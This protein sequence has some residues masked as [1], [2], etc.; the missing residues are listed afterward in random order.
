MRVLFRV[1]SGPTIG[2]GHAARS[3][4]LAGAVM[5]AGAEVTILGDHPDPRFITP[6]VRSGAIAAVGS[7]ADVDMGSYDWVVVDGYHLEDEVRAAAA[8]TTVAVIDDNRELPVELADLVLNQN[9][10]ASAAIYA[11][12]PPVGADTA[13][14]LGAAFVLLRPDVRSLIPAVRPE[15]QS[16]VMVS[17]GGADPLR[18]T[19]PVV[20]GLAERNIASVVGVSAGHPDR[21]ALGELGDSNA[22][23]TIDRGDLGDAFRSAGCGIIGGG[24]TLYEVAALGIPTVAVVTADNQREGTAAAVA[25]GIVRTSAAEASAIVDAIEAL[26][27]DDAG[28]SALATT[29][30]RLIDGR[31][32]DRVAARLLA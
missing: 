10:H 6:L 9:L 21:A 7:V 13:L 16:G 23:V 24:T 18:L 20:Q 4:T 25:A 22:F 29:G 5:A 11:T 12:P 19:L 28:R 1:D 30:R 15:D 26:R 31:G 27:A 2:F 17:F 8:S 32:A 3:S 14:C